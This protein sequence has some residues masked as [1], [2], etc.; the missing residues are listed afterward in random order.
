M[1]RP[2]I[3]TVKQEVDMCTFLPKL[4]I[5]YNGY[6][7]LT[8]DVEEV[9]REINSIFALDIVKELTEVIR[10][11]INEHLSRIPFLV[12]FK[13][14]TD[15]ELQQIFDLLGVNIKLQNS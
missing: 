7:L 10:E 12:P 13:L 4:V 11:D 6:K 8:V 1:P 14:F 15:E 3:F 2:R 5:S 9:N